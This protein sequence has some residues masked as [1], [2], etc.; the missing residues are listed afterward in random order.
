VTS[1]QLPVTSSATRSEG[2]RLSA[3]LRIP[4]GVAGSRPAERV[5]PS[6]QIAT[7]RNSRCTSRPIARPTQPST[8][9]AR[10]HSTCDMW[11]ENQRDN[12]THRYEL[13]TWLNPG[14]S[15]GRPNEKH[16]L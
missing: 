12:D 16:G 10:L 2:S 8:P 7:T 9:I 5:C 3:R 4:S 1:Q 13:L 11:R 14:K 15:Q 6:S